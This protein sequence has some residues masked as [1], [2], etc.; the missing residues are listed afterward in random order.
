MHRLEREHAT[1]QPEGSACPLDQQ[2][3][4]L[5][6]DSPLRAVRAHGAKS[7]ERIQVEAA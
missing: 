6:P 2:A 7:Q 5:T 3:L 1:L 4:M